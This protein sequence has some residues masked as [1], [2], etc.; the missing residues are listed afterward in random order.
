MALSDDG[1]PVASAAL[2]RRALEYARAF[3]LPLTVHEEDLAL[4]GKGVM[5][6]GAVSTRLG[7]TG[8]P[9]RPRTSWCCAT[10]RWPS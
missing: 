2:M 5:H 7:L 10:S 1:K 4:V 3:G 9:G 6:E 8:I